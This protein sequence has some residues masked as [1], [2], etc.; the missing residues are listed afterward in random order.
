MEAEFD[1]APAD[2]HATLEKLAGVASVT[3]HDGVMHI[4]SS[5]G[6][7]TVGA[8]MDLARDR[9]VNVRRVTVQGTTLDDVFLHYTGR[10]LRDEASERRAQLD[11]SHLVQIERLQLN[12]TER[13]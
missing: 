5:S 2:W 1:N 9:G 13:A 12:T 8:L 3:E 6:P 11:I 10:Q 4:S 7:V